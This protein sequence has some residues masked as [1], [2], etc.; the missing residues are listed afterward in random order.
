M[1]EY[2]E[3]YKDSEFNS[4]FDRV[5][6]GSSNDDELIDDWDESDNEV[7]MFLNKLSEYRCYEFNEVLRDTDKSH[8]IKMER[9]GNL[10][11]ISKKLSKIKGNFIFI[12]T[13]YAKK[14]TPIN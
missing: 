6:G 13:W 1:G 3:M 12:K 4:W 2:A 5:H 10:Y 11:W 8:L 14:L 7:P 9:S